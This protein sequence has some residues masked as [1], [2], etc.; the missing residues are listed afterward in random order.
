MIRALGLERR[1]GAKRVL[2]GVDLEVERG[3]SCST[4]RT[5]DSTIIQPV[6]FTRDRPQMSG[7]MFFTFCVS[8]AGMLLLAG[9]L[10][11][12]KLAGKRLELASRARERRG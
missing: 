6:V 4:S 3:S 9:T 1:Y 8:L 5:A 11:L 12:N 2:R 10:Y 7:D